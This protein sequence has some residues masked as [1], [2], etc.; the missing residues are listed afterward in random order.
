MVVKAAQAEWR[1]D[2]SRKKLI[3][4]A[5]GRDSHFWSHCISASPFCHINKVP[6]D[7]AAVATLPA[8]PLT[9]QS[10]NDGGQ[11]SSKRI[12]S[13]LSS[14]YRLSREVP[15]T[16]STCKTKNKTTVNHKLGL[17][18]KP[19]TKLNEKNSL[20]CRQTILLVSILHSNDETKRTEGM[21]MDI[22]CSSCYQPY[23]PTVQN[24]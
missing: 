3:H 5:R 9:H 4:N 1:N 16:I 23:H 10:L 12:L 2:W 18:V 11:H 14:M 13:F 24:Q 21:E 20:S 19:K 22:H 6:A 15:L 8:T 17:H 7:T